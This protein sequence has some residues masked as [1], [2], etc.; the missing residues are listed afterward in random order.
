VN[1]PALDPG[2]LE[3]LRQLNQEGQ[4]DVVHEVLTVFLSDAPLRVAAIEEAVRSGDATWVHRAAHA[5]KGAAGNIGATILH[6][7]CRELDEVAK[8][9]T[10]ARAPELARQIRE[11]F[12]RVRVEIAGILAAG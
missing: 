2:V 11:E 12:N 8:S 5:F 7:H 4:P 9:G 6:N 10:L 1:A 3:S